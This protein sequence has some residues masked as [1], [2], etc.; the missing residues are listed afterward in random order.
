MNLMEFFCS[1]VSS[2][3]LPAAFSPLFDETL[4]KKIAKGQFTLFAHRSADTLLLPVSLAS[5]L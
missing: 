3:R 2:G 4:L 5:H 1:S